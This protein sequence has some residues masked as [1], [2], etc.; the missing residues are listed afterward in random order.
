[1]ADIDVKIA[2]LIAGLSCSLSLFAM[3]ITG[4]AGS[5]QCELLLSGHNAQNYGPAGLL[6]V[7]GQTF[8]YGL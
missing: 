7:D 4:Q 2:G 6:S 5:S 8:R 1:L 3:G